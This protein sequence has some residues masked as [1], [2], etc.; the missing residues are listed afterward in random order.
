MSVIILFAFLGVGSSSKEKDVHTE[1]HYH[2]N[3][4]DNYEDSMGAYLARD[5][6]VLS[7]DI[8][9]SDTETK[10]DDMY[11]ESRHVP[12]LAFPTAYSAGKKAKKVLESAS[13]AKAM[14]KH[15][16]TKNRYEILIKP[17]LGVKKSKGGRK[18]GMVGNDDYV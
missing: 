12:S 18:F 10:H 11:S 8:G 17:D 15:R 7:N 3:D 14:K 16:K 6:D 5:P 2:Y 9:Y 13:F 1:Y 4:F